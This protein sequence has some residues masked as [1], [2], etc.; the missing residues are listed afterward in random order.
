V[1]EEAVAC[2]PMAL[3][4]RFRTGLRDRS[5]Q[6]TPSGLP[7]FLFSTR[8]ASAIGR[9]KSVSESRSCSGSDSHIQCRCWACGLFWLDE[10]RG[11]KSLPVSSPKLRYGSAATFVPNPRDGSRACGK[12]GGNDDIVDGGQSGVE[13]SLPFAFLR[14][15]AFIDFLPLGRIGP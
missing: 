2:T 12:L 4:L 11:Q 5:S 1:P 15:N 6:H 9:G 7:V 14:D 10:G 8:P 13:G 3:A